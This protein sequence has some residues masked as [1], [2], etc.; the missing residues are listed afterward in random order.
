MRQR[1]VITL[2]MSFTAFRHARRI[3]LTAVAVL[4]AV[5]LAA[6]PLAD[7]LDGRIDAGLALLYQGQYEEALDSFRS[8]S[9]G[10]PGN[11]AGQ[12]FIAGVYQLRGLA[13]ASDAWDRSYETALDSALALSDRAIK[14]N[15][16]D[17]WAYFFR[18]GT[19]AYMA[20]R[21]AR[22][23]SLLAALN[24]GLSGMS[25]L[26][27]A[28]EIDPVLYD[29]YLGLGSYHYFR[30]KAASVFKWLPFI[31]DRREQG[32]RELRTAVAQGRYTRV[33]AMNALMW[34][35]IDYG[36][37]DGALE[38][39]RQ[40]EQEYPA[41]HAFHWGAAEVHYK[42]GQWGPA[43]EAYERLLRMNEDAKPMNNYNR[44]F[45]KARLAKC[46]YEQGRYGEA[47]S[48]A[49]D[50]ITSPLTEDAARRLQRERARAQQVMKLSEKKAQRKQP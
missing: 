12:F 3:M 23:G 14:G 21:D 2:M 17:P 1:D 13:Y 6:A 49:R 29:A 27:R 15:P 25:D 22:N 18:G 46:R 4:A 26:K 41:N 38:A 28:V 32:V 42:R 50:A 48:L 44:V 37:L 19:F 34:I 5:P 39:A 11:P 36:K 7:D 33:M 47:E 45:I 8:F 35:L 24:K 30:T 40:L 9:S 31:G 20:S 10:H 16:K 43:G